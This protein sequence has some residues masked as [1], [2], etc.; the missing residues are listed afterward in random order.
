MSKQI[1]TLDSGEQAWIENAPHLRLEI[2]GT[3]ET[4][5]MPVEMSEIEWRDIKETMK[6]DIIGLDKNG[7]A[8]TLRS[9]KQETKQ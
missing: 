3:V 8:F 1:V 5:E 6:T 4:L 7:K 9:K 2:V